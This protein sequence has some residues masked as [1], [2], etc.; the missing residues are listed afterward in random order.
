SGS[1]IKPTLPNLVLMTGRR[2]GVEETMATGKGPIGWDES[3]FRKYESLQ[4]HTALAG[5]AML[6]A[7]MI[8]QRLGEIEE[9]TRTIPAP[10]EEDTRNAHEHSRSPRELDQ[11][12]SE[13]DLRIP[14]GDSKVPQHAD[15]EIPDD[16]GFV[17]LTINEILRISAIA[18]SGMSE[19]K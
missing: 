5:L 2:W 15:Q 3:Q 6:R 14:I 8:S 9:G 16:I 18:D 17:R 13:D 7:N 12:F 10:A 1:R 19:G 4:H 11:E